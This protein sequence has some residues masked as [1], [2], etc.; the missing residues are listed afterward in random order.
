[1]NIVA[2]V[3]RVPNTE[4]V[5]EISADGKGLDA[6]NFQ[7]IASFYDEIAVEQAVQTK[8]A[9]GGEVIV[10]SLGSAAGS[11]EIRESMAKGAD[12]AVLLVDEEWQSRD[13]RATAKALACQ[14]SELKADVVFMGKVATDRDN[15]AVGPMAAT[16]L[17]YACVTDV[18]ALELTATGGTAKRETEAGIETVEF[19]LPAV[20][21]CN[22]GLN[23]PRY[24]GLKGI[25]AAKK[26]PL[27]EVQVEV[28][29][30]QA[31]V[32][33]ASLPAPRKEGRI[34]GEGVAAVPALIQALQTETTLL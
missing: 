18:V 5:A 7:Y 6:K 1:M 3:K 32:V 27:D 23:E 20:I 22:K 15:G 31:Q 4:A 17:G 30:N 33:R 25:M 2:C 19:S 26:K 14:L 21:T 29:A 10:L 13:C 28:I 24:A 12:K 11:K 8:E 34:L 16:F 9:L